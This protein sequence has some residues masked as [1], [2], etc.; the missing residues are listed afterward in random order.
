MTLS[1]IPIFHEYK[2]ERRSVM[3]KKQNDFD[4]QYEYIYVRWITKGGKRIYP[5]NARV[6]RIKVKRR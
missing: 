5:K 1:S 2:Y 3:E 4:E 6:F